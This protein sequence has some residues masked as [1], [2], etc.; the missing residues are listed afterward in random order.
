MSRPR[1]QV[2]VA[3]PEMLA[4]LRDL[5]VLE[6]CFTAARLAGEGD[7]VLDALVENLFRARARLVEIERA[8]VRP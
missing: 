3:P 8:V 4:A 1:L 5:R 6:A 2:L 7:A